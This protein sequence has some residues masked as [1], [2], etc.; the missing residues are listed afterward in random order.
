VEL[1]DLREDPNEFH[2]VAE[3]GEYGGVREELDARLWGFLL[4]HNDFV[5][6]EPVRTDWQE[7]TRR[8]LEDYLRRRGAS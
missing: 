3:A 7:E 5:V 2:N 8:H 6:N 4:Q 1:Y